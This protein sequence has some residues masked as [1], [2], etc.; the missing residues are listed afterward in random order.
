MPKYPR[1]ILNSNGT[2][3]IDCKLA[4][5]EWVSGDELVLTIRVFTGGR[6][7]YTSTVHFSGVTNRTEI[8]DFMNKN[9]TKYHTLLG[10]LWEYERNKYA[11]G[12]GLI[13]L[14]RSV[15]VS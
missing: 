5:F 8:N 9:R 1:Q 2:S 15:Y 6:T 7:S 13:V 12:D 4:G 14:A 3:F 10:G 11:L